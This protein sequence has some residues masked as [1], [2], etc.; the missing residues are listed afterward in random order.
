M[1][2]Q[3]VTFEC[4]NLSMDSESRHIEEIQYEHSEHA[5]PG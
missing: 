2:L 5:N 1:N 3:F 4:T